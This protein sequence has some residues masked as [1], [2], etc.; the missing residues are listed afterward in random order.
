MKRKYRVTPKGKVVFSIAGILALVLLFMFIQS[1]LPDQVE[2]AEVVDKS[3]VEAENVNAD[4]KNVGSLVDENDESSKSEDSTQ[5]EASSEN[6]SSEMD[7]QTTDVEE[8]G[9]EVTEESTEVEIS[10]VD[11]EAL[12]NAKSTI[13]FEPDKYDLNDEYKLIL[14]IFIGVAKEYPDEVIKVEGNINGYPKFNDS[15]F[16]EELSQIRADKVAQYL[17]NMG[18]PE[19]KIIV[20]SNGSSKP[21]NKSDSAE[22]LMLNRRTD[23]Y[24]EAYLL[25]E[26][27]SK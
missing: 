6:A 11:V 20:Q 18:I 12:V 3:T 5:E 2:P 21:L 22:E 23:V 15:K 13:Y 19:E 27:D 7:E 17:K 26:P 8:P 10:E 24:F 4:Q 25:E 1:L 14:N 16:G 9:E